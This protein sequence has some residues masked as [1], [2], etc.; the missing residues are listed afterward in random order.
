M[1]LSNPIHLVFLL[2]VLTIYLGLCF[3]A[4]R[5][6][7]RKGRSFALWAGITFAF[8]PVVLF[9]F[10]LPS[11]RSSAPTVDRQKHCPDCAERVQAAAK[12]CKHCGYR[13]D[14]TDTGVG[15]V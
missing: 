7:E 10:L 6:A 5:V 3:F 14:S 15:T 1:G 12:V 9:I 13:F 2:I 11:K 4:G 8:W